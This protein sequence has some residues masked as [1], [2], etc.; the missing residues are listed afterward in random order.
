[1]S[2]LNKNKNEEFDEEFDNSELE[3][4][5]DVRDKKNVD[6][7]AVALSCTAI[8][9]AL[10]MGGTIAY[11]VH[12]GALNDDAIIGLLDSEDGKDAVTQAFLSAI[13]DYLNGDISEDE[14]KQA[15]ANL[16]N[17]Y[18]AS[19]NGFTDQQLEALNT[20]IA[21]YLDSTTI[22]TD[23]EKNEQSIEALKK[24]I[25]EKYE[26]NYNYISEVES[27]LS[28]LIESNTVND[29]LRYQELVAADKQLKS[30]LDDAK[31]GLHGE[32][33]E[34]K[35]SLTQTLTD[36]T[37]LFMNT[38]G[39]SKWESGVAYG[40]G[41]YVFD[42]EYMYVSL[43]NGNTAP[44]SDTTA[45]EKTDIKTL[46]ERMDAKFMAAI[47]AVKYDGGSTYGKGD[48]VFDQNG[49]FY[50][51]I[52]DGNT[53]HD[54][55]DTSAWKKT[56]IETI[57][58]DMNTTLQ[59][60]I[61][62]V[63][64]ADTYKDGASY[65]EGDYVIYQGNLY[66]SNVNDNT[67]PISDSTGWTK[68]DLNTIINEL[69]KGSEETTREL[70]DQLKEIII[71]QGSDYKEVTDALK[72]EIDTNK[73]LS[74]EQKE[75]LK[76][77]IDENQDKSEA[78]M[79]KLTED[80]NYVIDE[81]IKEQDAA[82]EDLANKVS[83]LKDKSAADAQALKDEIDANK[84]LS[85]K[86]KEDM[87][88]L[89]DKN[90]KDSKDDMSNLSDSLNDIIDKNKKEAEAAEKTLTG[91]IDALKDSTL[92]D[93]DALEKKINAK[94]DAIE[95]KQS[96][97]LQEVKENLTGII[98]ANEKLSEE[99]REKLKNLVN[100]YAEENA[101][102][103]GELETSLTDTISAN[104]ADAD[105][106]REALQAYIDGVKADGLTNKQALK[107]EIDANKA[108][109]D[110]EK[111]EMKALIDS[112]KDETEQGIS[113]LS[114]ALTKVINKN[115]ADADAAYVQVVDTIHALENS[116][117]TDIDAVRKALEE[118]SK[119]RAQIDEQLKA[120]DAATNSNLSKETSERKAA[121]AKEAKD[122][123]AADTKETNERKAADTKE[124]KERTDADT[125]LR[126]DLVKEIA[127]RTAGDKQLAA[128]ILKEKTAL[129]S[130]IDGKYNLEASDRK[131]ADDELATAIAELRVSQSSSL[132]EVQKNLI[133]QINN[134]K[135]F[136]AAERKKMTDAITKCDSD[137][138]TSLSNLSTELKGI[139]DG[140]ASLDEAER[141]KIQGSV[142]ALKDATASDIAALKAGLEKKIS[143]L[144]T[145]VENYNKTIN[146]K[147]DNNV[148]NINAAITQLQNMATWSKDV[149]YDNKA[150]VTYYNGNIQR[151]YHSLVNNNKG[152]EPGKAGS[153]KFWE[154]VDTLSL[155]KSLQDQITDNKNHLL[156]SNGS[157]EEFQY[158]VSNGQRGYYV[159]GQFKPF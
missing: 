128:D 98:D 36:L 73:A 40:Y 131:K 51:S 25:N 103:L 81:A 102:H 120:A 75:A 11:N 47:G 88:N 48:Y 7:K 61:N 108:L 146:N 17:D 150:Y 122:R 99:E 49:T 28:K 127:D 95:I 149:T 100:N 155:V 154:E 56:D 15:I 9:I 65:K 4:S 159:N 42:N 125:K 87:K 158:G 58:K 5:V 112:N 19:T 135:K 24:L 10:L 116:T 20:I 22:Y 3:D 60:L 21:E 59:D 132:S 16:I 71:K 104:K 117:A 89:I 144:N 111:K 8:A 123:A 78:G 64:G 126:Q 41:S 31:N 145:K 141:A 12:K 152:H 62:S 66:V 133:N 74:D 32:I 1:M 137:S 14:L 86:E 68:S 114:D 83:E 63:I 30:W 2:L 54:L 143:D 96:S 109:S 27:Q 121:D 79:K 106:A 139:I 18:L 80:M 23:I 142:N 35:T 157:G 84:A 76:T 38:V 119:I 105:A 129:Q 93:L 29:D 136:T 50:I 91:Q 148:T 33:N 44:L 107:D 37:K 82:R 67:Y 153:E 90:A 70:Y 113:N 115:K 52:M 34:T 55:S 124:T 53:G 92:A 101:L 46:L 140:N 97:D 138:K 151:F 147:I 77:M 94:L 45:W 26:S 39:G 110:A 134:E 118:E 13:N 130:Y 69:T 57:I 6:K 43:V 72:K 156:D 85:D